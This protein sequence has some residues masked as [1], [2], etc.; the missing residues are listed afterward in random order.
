MLYE[1]GEILTTAGS[2]KALQPPSSSKSARA[3]ETAA[4]PSRMITS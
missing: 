1:D 3:K 2:T 4:E